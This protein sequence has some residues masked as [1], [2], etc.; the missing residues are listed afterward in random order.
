M[1]CFLWAVSTRKSSITLFPGRFRLAVARIPQKF[2]NPFRDGQTH[3]L[4]LSFFR[5]VFVQRRNELNVKKYTACIKMFLKVCAGSSS[6]CLEGLFCS[7][8]TIIY[9]FCYP[10]SIRLP[11]LKQSHTL[12]QRIC[13]GTT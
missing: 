3:T 11:V 4:F 7:L 10:R 8:H 12:M 1:R 9:D 5:F 2:Q 6:E 13:R